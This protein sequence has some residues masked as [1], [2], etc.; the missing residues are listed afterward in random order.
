MAREGLA[1]IGIDRSRAALEAG[2]DAA[3]R[4]NL[5]ASFVQADLTSFTF[6]ANALS[7]VLC[8]KYRNPEH[9]PSI[10][11]TLR[12]GG[13]LICETYTCEHAIYDLKPRNPEHMLE[14]GE[15][16]RAFCDWEIIFYREV[17]MGRGIASLAARKTLLTG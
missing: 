6:P 13:V 11:A 10:R 4:A 9:Y 14:R 17:W 3:I 7:V 2:R 5:N 8:F 1:A 16:Y 15:L 12:P